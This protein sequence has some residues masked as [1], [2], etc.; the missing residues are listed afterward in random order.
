MRD[1]LCDK[2]NIGNLMRKILLLITLSLLLFACKEE[3][4]I[5]TTDS[6]PPRLNFPDTVLIIEIKDSN[7]QIKFTGT[8]KI[9]ESHTE[10]S[11]KA[12]TRVY[13]S[14]YL[15]AISEN[16][17]QLDYELLQSRYIKVENHT[18]ENKKMY[19]S[20]KPVDI[21]LF[22]NKLSGKAW[23]SHTILFDG[24]TAKMT[25]AEYTITLKKPDKK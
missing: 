8:K 18:D 6:P 22:E 24:S 21:Y 3:N 9:S 15:W 5:A 20:T 7:G 2:E 25:F 13:K 17:L 1:F 19:T 12:K 4:N 11:G 14:S 16:P 23:E 10:V